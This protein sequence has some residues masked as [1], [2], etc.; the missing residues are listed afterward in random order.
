MDATGPGQQSEVGSRGAAV[1]AGRDLHAELIDLSEACFAL[2]A[3]TPPRI[4][5]MLRCMAYR[6]VRLA[7]QEAHH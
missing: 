3:G 7:G 5:R 1:P 4:K 6:M 2:A